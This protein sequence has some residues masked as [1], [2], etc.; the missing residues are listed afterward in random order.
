MSESFPNSTPAAEKEKS[1]EQLLEEMVTRGQLIAHTWWSAEQG[2]RLGGK[3]EWQSFAGMGNQDVMAG[4]RKNVPKNLLLHLRGIG[5]ETKPFFGKKLYPDSVKGLDGLLREQ[6][7]DAALTVERL[8]KKE[9][10]MEKQKYFEKEHWYSPAKEKTRDVKVGEKEVQVVASQINGNPSDTE[11]AYQVVL[12]R[13]VPGLVGGRPG[14][15]CTYSLLLPE[16]QAREVFE[17]LSRQPSA[18]E[19]MVKKFDPV[20]AEQLSFVPKEVKRLLLI[21]EGQAEQAYDA[22]RFQVKK[23]KE[24]FVRTI[25]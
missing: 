1:R 20:M 7:I 11:P 15:S 25:S 17:L 6:N 5:K 16:R 19:E 13:T 18:I 2:R 9:V 12:S 23:I 10:I 24:E 22:E 3:P 8:I 14:V 21:P 4:A